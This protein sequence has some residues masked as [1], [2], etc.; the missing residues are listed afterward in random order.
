MKEVITIYLRNKDGQFIPLEFPNEEGFSLMELLRASELPVLGTCGGISLCGSCH[1]YI[2]SQH[3]LHPPSD[4][5]LQMLDTLHNCKSNS[6]LSC[7][8][9]INESLDQLK[10]ELAGSEF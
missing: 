6:R 10:I 1:I 5:E 3:A 9:R 7:Q 2:H 4:E 8:L